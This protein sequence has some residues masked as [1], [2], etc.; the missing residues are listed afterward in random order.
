MKSELAALLAVSC[1]VAG[2]EPPKDYGRCLESHKETY[3]HSRPLNPMKPLSPFRVFET[4]TRTV[5]DRWEFP[6]GR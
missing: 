3:R 4:R 6:D 2:C 5:C 1:L